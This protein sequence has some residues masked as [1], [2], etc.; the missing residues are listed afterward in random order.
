MT[1]D[2]EVRLFSTL[3]DEGRV[4][5]HVHVAGLD[6][7]D[8]VNEVLVLEESRGLQRVTISIWT[9]NA[10]VEPQRPVADVPVGKL[11]AGALTAE[12]LLG[13]STEETPTPA[14]G[15]P[16][17]DALAA[18][19]MQGVSAAWPAPVDLDQL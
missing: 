12:L 14:Y 15:T 5:R 4:Q 7:T 3:N 16:I 11:A 10:T 6:L 19:R 13:G 18:E 1:H 17:A 9:N 2:T 8:H